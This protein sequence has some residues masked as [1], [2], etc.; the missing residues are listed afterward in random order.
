[1]LF[2]DDDLYPGAQQPTPV[3][4]ELADAE[5]ESSDDPESADE[6]E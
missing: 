6:V 3:E 1:M 4:A 2:G 5:G